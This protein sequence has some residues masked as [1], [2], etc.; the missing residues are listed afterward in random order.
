[1][2]GWLRADANELRSDEGLILACGVLGMKIYI[3]GK[4]YGERDAKV[5][6]FDHGLLYG[7]GVFEGIRAY[8]GRVFKLKEH[9]DRLFWSAQAILLR[10][11]LTRAGWRKRCSR[12]AGRIGFGMAMSGWWSREGAGR[13]D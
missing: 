7:D 4:Y 10:I 1:M 6:V 3:D 2:A 8:N 9:V 5:S 12:P 11:P 13:W